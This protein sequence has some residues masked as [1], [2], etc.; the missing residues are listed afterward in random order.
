MIIDTHCHLSY[1]DYDNIDEIVQHMDGNIM[2]ISGVNDE[3]NQEVIRYIEQY[4]NVYGMV[5]IHPGDID[6]I[7]ETTFSSLEEFLKNPKIV[8]VGEIGLDYHYPNIDKEKQKNILFN[9]FYL[10]KNIISQL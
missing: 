1:E 7:T 6:T 4:E 3:T 10:Q 5:G 9:K 2:I 8:A